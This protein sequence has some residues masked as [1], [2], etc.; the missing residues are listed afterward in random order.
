MQAGKVSYADT[1]RYIQAPVEN[2]RLNFSKRVK[3]L[4]L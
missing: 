3:P 2:L 1:Q 4:T